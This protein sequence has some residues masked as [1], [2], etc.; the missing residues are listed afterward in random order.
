[1]S[2]LSGFIIAFALAPVFKCICQSYQINLHPHLLELSSLLAAQCY[3]Y[4]KIYLILFV[5]VVLL[6]PVQVIRASS[7]CWSHKYTA[8]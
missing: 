7:Q 1:M 2:P 8:V 4:K 3:S 6:P 5:K